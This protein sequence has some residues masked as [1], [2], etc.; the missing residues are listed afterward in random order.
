MI[1]LEFTPAQT[2]TCS[3]PDLSAWILDHTHF[4]ERPIVLTG[5][6]QARLSK[7]RDA[8]KR[9]DLARSLMAVRI[10]LADILGRSP[11][12]IMIDRDALGA[13]SLAHVPECH[14]SISRTEGW[15]AFVL[16]GAAAVGID[17]ERVRPLSWR[18]MMGMVCS[19]RETGLLQDIEEAAPLPFYR[20]WTAKE[21]LMKTTGQGFRMGAPGIDLPESFIMGKTDHAEVQVMAR[22]FGISCSL[23][24]DI[25]A[26]VA[27]EAI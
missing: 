20:L 22:A 16:S 11:A 10:G 2:R 24:G 21:A 4:P 15:S 3:R 12:D 25:I 9:T 1:E 8:G 13:P 14:L 23:H 27:A 17:I 26:S 5:A 7:L 18:Q 19:P 6:E